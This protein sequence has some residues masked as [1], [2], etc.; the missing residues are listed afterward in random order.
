M[1]E[2]LK[3]KFGKLKPQLNERMRRLWAAMEA[4]AIGRGGIA[5]VSRQTGLSR[6]TIQAGLDELKAPHTFDHQTHNRMLVR[7]SGG[8]RKSLSHC[9]PRLLEA[10]ESL[11]EP[12]SHSRPVE[13]LRWTAKS[14]AQLASELEVQGHD[15]SQRTVYRLLFQLGYKLQK[16]KGQK[17]VRC[18]QFRHI[19]KQVNTF[20]QRGQP[21]VLIDLRKEEVD[22]CHNDSLES[23]KGQP[24]LVKA[25]DMMDQ[26]LGK[27]GL[28]GADDP[29]NETQGRSVEID[30]DTV[31]FAIE[32]LQRWWSRMGRPVYRRAKHLLIIIDGIYPNEDTNRLWKLNLQGLVDKLEIQLS[33][34]YFPA[35]TSKWNLIQHQMAVRTTINRPD[36]PSVHHEVVVS[37]IGDTTTKIGPES[38]SEADQSRDQLD[39]GAANQ[40]LKVL[41][42]EQDKFQGNWNYRLLPRR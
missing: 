2:D 3:D 13:P 27:A 1:T 37:L 35:G 17:T 5:S 20:H 42:I 23:P 31:E 28:G 7:R 18:E 16:A 29:A 39:S 36:R 26:E 14:A 33:V 4:Q 41:A 9:D 8:G 10:L 6:S 19:H 22:Q 15:I 32:T 25:H 34:C 30:H 21:V 12:V 24:E 11:I 38:H 40:Q